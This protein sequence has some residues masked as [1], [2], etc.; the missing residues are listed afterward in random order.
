MLDNRGCAQQYYEE[1]VAHFFGG[2]VL[3]HFEQIMYIYCDAVLSADKNK[4]NHIDLS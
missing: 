2:L 4:S 3:F 1:K